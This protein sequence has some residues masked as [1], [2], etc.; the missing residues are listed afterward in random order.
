MT[1]AQLAGVILGLSLVAALTIVRASDPQPLRLAREATFDQYQRLA[2]RRFESMP[3]RV[4]DIDEASLQQF[5]QWPW[6]RDRMAAMIEKLTELGAAAIAFDILFAE[7]DR[8]SPRTVLRDVPGIDPALLD[9]LPDNDEIFAGSIAGKPVIL[10]YGI[11]N[12]GNYRPQIKAGI[13]F[14]GESPIAAP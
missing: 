14:M 1:R 11:S 13:A 2:P 8:L 3:V 9:R 4:V 7:P 6:P 5:G 10:G 12:E